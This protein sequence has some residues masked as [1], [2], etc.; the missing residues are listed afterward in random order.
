LAS[1]LLSGNQQFQHLLVQRWS[2]E[3][4]FSTGR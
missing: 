2:N 1:V 4:K 3:S